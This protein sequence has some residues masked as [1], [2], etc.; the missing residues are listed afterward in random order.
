MTELLSYLKKRIKP[1]IKS[2]WYN[3][4]QY[5]CFLVAM[6]VT[7]IFCGLV[8]MAA[9]NNNVL[10]R[11]YITEEYGHHLELRNLNSDQY[12]YM[13]ND[14]Y[15]V[16]A[17]QHIYDTLGEKVHVNE[18][19]GKKTYTLYIRFVGEPQEQYR[20]FQK[21]YFGELNAMAD[22][23]EFEVWTTPLYNFERRIAANAAGNVFAFLLVT[24]LSVALV[25]ALYNIRVNHNKFEYGIY[26]T[27]GADFK[28]LLSTSLWEMLVVAVAAYIPAT[29]VS[30][31]I[32]LIVYKSAGQSYEYFAPT[33]IIIFVFALL[34]A[35]LS[36]CMPIWLLSRRTPRSNIIAEDNSNLVVSPRISF[37][38]LGKTYPRGY[39]LISAW[40]FRLYSLRLFAVVSAL[41]ALFTAMVYG[42]KLID[43]K[44]DYL[45]P[46]FFINLGA[47]GYEYDGGKEG[48]LMR[49]ELLGIPGVTEI[50]KWDT[51]EA[52]ELRSHVM[53]DKKNV[54]FFANYVI[55]EDGKRATNLVY[56]VGADSE[57]I[58]YL[59]RYDIE[60]DPRSILENEK[61]VIV[62]DSTNIGKKLKIKPGD[63]IWVAKY[64][65]KIVDPSPFLSENQ[66]LKA[67]LE[68]YYF[69]Y[70]EYTVGAVIHNYPGYKN[71]TV[72]FSDGGFDEAAGRPISHTLVQLGIDA[73]LTP[74]E[75]SGIEQDLRRWAD[76]YPGVKITNT[77]SL[78]EQRITIA[79]NTTAFIIC[80]AVLTL[81]VTPIVW[82]FSQVLFSL[83]R[84]GEFNVLLA[85]GGLMSELRRQLIYDGLISTVTSG[86][87]LLALMFISSYAVC[88]AGNWLVAFLTKLPVR[89]VFEVPWIPVAVGMVLGLVSA[90][91]SCYI[92][93][94]LFKRRVDITSVT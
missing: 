35:T 23:G 89:Y 36:V 15:T 57:T 58:E 61:T 79:K 2:V 31:L 76:Y 17:S 45:W 78:G 43:I 38:M 29:V 25:T 71:I 8:V 82:F 12:Y 3:R 75:V 53:F 48:G 44:N 33:P 46:Q 42:A 63:K 66:L 24:A 62:T 39:E 77:L 86:V 16:F 7:E 94:I 30:W 54:T 11:K 26:M 80:I 10:E 81:T 14:I 88:F 92:P 22:P 70:I 51:L 5:L 40:R 41:T 72:F 9:H 34:V 19:T 90:F 56:Y 87:M 20:E 69:D 6:F 21:R 4:T 68:Y 50:I 85:L 27:F 60:G 91:L 67:Q 37:E 49:E 32:S 47:G 74:D 18:V 28:R 84:E 83:K 59:S 1:A 52:P 13:V 93:Y 55:P 65:G 73:S 64:K